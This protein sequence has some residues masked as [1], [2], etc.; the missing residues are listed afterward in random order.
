MVQTIVPPTRKAPARLA[1]K[2]AARQQPAEASSRAGMIVMIM[3]S[4]VLIVWIFA[5]TV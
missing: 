1:G 4:L 5:G 3:F 2:E